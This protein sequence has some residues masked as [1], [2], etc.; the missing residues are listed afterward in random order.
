VVIVAN[1]VFSVCRSPYRLVYIFSIRQGGCSTILAIFIGL[2]F[3]MTKRVLIADDNEFLRRAIRSV[4]EQQLGLEICAQ[5]AAGLETLHAAIA[6]RPDLLILDLRMPELNGAEVAGL[7]KKNLPDSKI[8]FFTMYDEALRPGLA[9]MLGANKVVSKAEGLSVLAREVRRLLGIPER[10]GKQV[11]DT[12]E[13]LAAAETLSAALHDSEERFRA[14]FEQTAVGLAHVT[15]DGHWLKVNGK[16][17]EILGYSETDLKSMSLKDVA[18]PDDFELDLAQCRRIE[19]GEIDRYSMDKR[20]IRGDGKIVSVRLTVN[21]IRNDKGKL[22]YCVRVVEQRNGSDPEKKLSETLSSGRIAIGQLELVSE[23]WGAPLTHCSRDL[24]YLWVNRYYADWLRQTVEK[25]VGRPILD[26]LGK[27]AFETLQPRFEQVLRGKAVA[28]EADA[29]YREIG[30]RRISAAYRPV[31]D[32][33]GNTEGWVALV[34]DL[35]DVRKC[36]PMADTDGPHS[37]HQSAS[38]YPTP[39]LP[40]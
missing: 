9:N 36:E 35:T 12:T 30:L 4:L 22:K 14:T 26:I 5:T 23:R 39:D 2:H 16:F 1:R 13:T 17:C 25:I 37:T 28:Y 40:Q 10:L 32:G 15:T 38:T 19:A 11:A 21:G 18:H 31:I 24:R 20:Y 27:D 3:Q 7:L 29:K 6:L 34:E 8:I 33:N